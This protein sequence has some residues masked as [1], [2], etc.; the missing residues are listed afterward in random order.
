MTTPYQPPGVGDIVYL[1]SCLM[2]LGVDAQTTPPDTPNQYSA[3]LG[4]AG[5]SGNM[6]LDA[7]MGAQGPDG[8]PVF[9]L[10]YQRSPLYE[11]PAAL[12]TLTS[13]PDDIGKYWLIDELDSNGFYMTTWC[14]IWWGS[15][16]RQIMMGT[17]GAPGPVPQ[18]NPDIMFVPPGSPAV[19]N[20]DGSTVSPTW[21]FLLPS[22][23]GAPG[24]VGLFG[25][26]P[27]VDEVT[28]APSP[29]NVL[30]FLGQYTSNT[31][32]LP[33]APLWKP[34][35]IEQFLPKT[36][37]MPQ[38][39][40]TPYIGISQQANIGSMTLPA[41]PYAW[42]PAVWG[43]L[44]A[45][46]L[47]LGSDPVC[48]GAEVLLN[49][50]TS[51]T[52]VARGIGTTL[53]NI[54]IVPHYSSSYN[55]N[56]NIT[57][58][59]GYAVVPAGSTAT[60]YVNLW[61]DGKMGY[62]SFTPNSSPPLWQQ[63]LDNL[64]KLLGNAEA[65]VGSVITQL[66]NYAGSVPSQIQ[67]AL[68]SVGQMIGA[69]QVGQFV[70]HSVEQVTQ[71]LTQFQPLL[72]TLANDLGI[73]AIEQNL[74]NVANQLNSWASTISAQLQNSIDSIAQQF[75]FPNPGNPATA[76]ANQLANL[77]P[78]LQHLADILGQNPITGISSLL[79]SF[80]G[81]V[82]SDIR[83][84]ID[85]VAGALGLAANL[86]PNQLKNNLN[87][88]QSN[89]DAVAVATGLSGV[90]HDI[91]T[92]INAVV[93]FIGQALSGPLAGLQTAIDAVM[94]FLGSTGIDHTIM[95]LIDKLLGLLGNLFSG[96]TTDAQLFVTVTPLLA[97]EFS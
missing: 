53:G 12:P 3:T 90:G 66:N 89:L 96:Y 77:Q 42:T 61:N 72:T 46:G 85:A 68:N 36:Y 30:A 60:L 47:S 35:N 83:S 51:G 74:A 86:T 50:A 78:E 37:S 10:K 56:A 79:S 57:P 11:T 25:E 69:S 40:F 18:I 8:Q 33:G 52:M 94:Q 91:N 44:A 58:K 21:Q 64:A 17:V 39:S 20:V 65:T 38:S 80:S 5:D 55:V 22:P 2:N 70:N 19:I 32:A 84:S 76:I 31:S 92:V 59:N 48:I 28:T 7:V 29:Y 43:H 73:T 9:Q 15:Y 27:D 45:G 67:A 75:G 87:T 62:Y 24:P 16:Y 93:P 1:T 34:F 13:S 23:T 6:N 82:T 14:Y 26:F 4:V 54:N 49:N 71:Y 88:L 97:G 95:D 41:Q 81:T 63:E